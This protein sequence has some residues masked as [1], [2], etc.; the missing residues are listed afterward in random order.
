MNLAQHEQLKRAYSVDSQSVRYDA[1]GLSFD[2]SARQL[3]YRN[4]ILR[5]DALAPNT[6]SCFGAVLLPFC[7]FLSCYSDCIGAFDRTE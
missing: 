6:V 3:S 4:I 5:L 7:C 2:R 1:G